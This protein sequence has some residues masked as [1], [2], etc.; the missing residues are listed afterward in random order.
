MAMG[1]GA[2]VVTPPIAMR[3]LATAGTSYAM[4]H[5]DAWHDVRP[6]DHPS[7][8]V[9]LSGPPWHRDMPAEPEMPQQALSPEAIAELLGTAAALLA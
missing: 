7:V 6:I 9:M 3:I 8:S 1:Y 5:R 2:G 4:T